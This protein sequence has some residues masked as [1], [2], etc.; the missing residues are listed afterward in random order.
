MPEPPP[1]SMMPAEHCETHPGFTFPCDGCL[2]ARRT[3]EA[4]LRALSG[5]TAVDRTTAAPPR[6]P[7]PVPVTLLAPRPA[8]TSSSSAPATLARVAQLLERDPP[9][10]ESMPR[11]IWGAPCSTPGCTHRVQPSRDGTKHD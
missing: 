10:E 3:R 6:R 11:G 9:K 1:A 2:G 8:P 7:L 4:M 5:R